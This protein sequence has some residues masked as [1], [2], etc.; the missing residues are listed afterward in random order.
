MKRVFVFE[1]LTGASAIDADDDATNE[2]LTMGLAMRDALVLDLLRGKNLSISAATNEAAPA[3][4]GHT[5]AARD[6]RALK[7]ESTLEFVARQSALHDL[8]WIVA[9]ETGGLLAQFQR[10]VGVRRWLG[11]DAAAIVLAASKRSTSRRL[12]GRDVAT[13]WAFRNAPDV[14]RWVVKPDDGAGAVG[15]Q[16]H[17]SRSAALA[18]ASS[19][20]GADAVSVIEPWVEGEP[21]SLSL[22]CS[23]SG[24]EL[25][26]INRQCI[27]IDAHG[28]VSFGGV[29]INAVPLAGER[30]HALQRL[31]D[32]VVRAMPGL[33]G[34]VGIDLVWHPQQGPVVIEVNPRLTCA[35]V[36]LSAALGR[37]LAAE[38][39]A[40]HTTAP[41]DAASHD[42]AH[43][44]T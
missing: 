8:S 7:G 31:A 35:Y 37:N 5:P 29:E 4:P 1:Y 9:P 14:T 41:S 22:L 20:H 40:G 2:L 24:A 38:L 42:H 16:V 23:H 34:F 17:T 13:P 18:D 15:T 44:H 27:H 10:A 33:H 6:V 36:G 39:V 21:L 28:I 30:G 43:A 12:A 32:T 11:C 3:L 19:P 26:S 25:L